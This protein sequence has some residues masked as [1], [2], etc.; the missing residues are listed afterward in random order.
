MV[1]KYSVGIIIDRTGSVILEKKMIE[2]S[3]KL[4]IE[5]LVSNYSKIKEKELV[6]TFIG[7]E[8]FLLPQ[9]DDLK[10]TKLSGSLKQEKMVD[11][12]NIFKILDKISLE[13]GMK[14]IFF[15]SD[16]Y[17]TEKDD[18]ESFITLLNNNEKK[19]NEIEKIVIGIGEGVNEN[20]L[21]SFSSKGTIF[22]YKDIYDLV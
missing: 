9:C 17:L 4:M 7:E 2:A 6:V 12:T 19:Y 13:K 3:L 14:K 22:Q 1:E 5:S 11:Y 16:G 21:K 15:F 20:I 18:W 8:D 10:I